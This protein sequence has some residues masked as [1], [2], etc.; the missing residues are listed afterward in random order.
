MVNFFVNENTNYD[1]NTGEQEFY[2]DSVDQVENGEKPYFKIHIKKVGVNLYDFGSINIYPQGSIK[3]KHIG[4]DNML[5]LLQCLYCYDFDPLVAKVTENFE[6]LTIDDQVATLLN[7]LGNN[8]IKKPFIVLTTKKEVPAM[9][10]VDGK[11]VEKKNEDGTTEMKQKEVFDRKQTTILC[12]QK[13]AAFEN[14]DTEK[15]LDD[16]IPF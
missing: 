9:Q 4:V 7:F 6:T 16:D 10:Q 2:I 3:A 12:K 8:C 5:F 14:P 1:Y 15:V 13:I 11:W